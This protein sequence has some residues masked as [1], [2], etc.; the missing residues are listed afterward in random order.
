MQGN[1]DVLNESAYTSIHQK[2]FE[3]GASSA[4][5]CVVTATFAGG[6]AC[7]LVLWQWF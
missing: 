3:Q 2:A 5:L 6:G 1:V 4:C 7:V